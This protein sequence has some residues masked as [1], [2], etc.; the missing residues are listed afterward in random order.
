MAEGHTKGAQRRGVKFTLP[1]TGRPQRE[2]ACKLSLRR[3]ARAMQSFKS[4][5]WEFRFSYSA[6]D[7]LI[8][9]LI[10]IKILN[11]HK[12]F[13]KMLTGI[14]RLAVYSQGAPELVS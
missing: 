10:I 4:H 5:S 9:Q 13:P 6:S 8:Q 14:T 1:G 3:R 11:P 2:G 12:S 7:L